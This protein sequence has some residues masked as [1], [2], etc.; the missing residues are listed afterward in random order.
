MRGG[1]VKL[2]TIMMPPSEFE[3][4]E[5]GDALYGMPL[6]YIYPQKEVIL[7]LRIGIIWGLTI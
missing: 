4:A 1:R 7:I 2:Y 3:H 6:F 5:K